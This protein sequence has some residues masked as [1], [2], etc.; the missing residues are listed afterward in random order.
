MP[1]APINGL[2][3]FYEDTAPQGGDAPVLVFL[4]GAAGNHMSWWQQVPTFRKAYRCISIDHRGFGRSVDPVREDGTKEGG[5]RFIDDLEALVE[6]LGLRDVF[7][8][9]QSMG[10]RAALGYACRR[11]D[12]VRALAMADTWGFFE[13]PEQ[14]ERAQALASATTTPLVHRA[15]AASFQE[16]NPALTFLYRQIEGLNPPREGSPVPP[17]P[18]GPTLEQVR[19]LSVPVL[20]LVGA[21]DAVTPPPLIKA[22]ADELPNSQY[23]EVPGAGH[24]VYFEQPRRFNE[25]VGDFLARHGGIPIS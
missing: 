20:C 11:P 17:A 10:G 4:H 19:A 21:E 15:L 2:D 22:L 8:V 6:H 1:T 5:A 3:L 9:A 25:I 18:N 16:Q 24:S 23:V 14:R 13:W 12:N 7:L